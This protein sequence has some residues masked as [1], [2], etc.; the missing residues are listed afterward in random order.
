MKKKCR[1]CKKEFE[2][3]SIRRRYCDICRKKREKE[4]Q[5]FQMMDSDNP[6]LEDA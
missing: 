2:A 3:R 6:N 1:Q 4:Y 5:K